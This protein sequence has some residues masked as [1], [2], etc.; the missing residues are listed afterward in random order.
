[1]KKNEED[2]WLIGRRKNQTPWDVGDKGN[3]KITEE[4]KNTMI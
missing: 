3:Q 2:D 1:M 4:T